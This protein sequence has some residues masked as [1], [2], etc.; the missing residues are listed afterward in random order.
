MAKQFMIDDNI[1]ILC[2]TFKNIYCYEIKKQQLLY[3]ALKSLEVPTH[4]NFLG[5]KSFE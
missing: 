5:S 2:T 1:I 4:S 3:I